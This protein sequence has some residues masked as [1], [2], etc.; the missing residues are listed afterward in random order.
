MK[1]KPTEWEGRSNDYMA[2]YLAGLEYGKD[3]AVK[4][5]ED[6][7]NKKRRKVRALNVEI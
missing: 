1:N 4:T 5:F 6:A 7:F 3:F 2:G